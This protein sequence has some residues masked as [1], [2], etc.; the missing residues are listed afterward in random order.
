MITTLEHV[1]YHEFNTPMNAIVTLADCLEVRAK[2]QTDNELVE[3]C[4][5]L[6]SSAYRLCSTFTKLATLIQLTNDASA[7]VK[8]IQP[9]DIGLALQ[10][11]CTKISIEYNR[12]EDLIFNCGRNFLINVNKTYLESALNEIVDNAFKFSCLGQRV[13]IAIDGSWDKVIIRIADEGNT[14]NAQQ[15]QAC[16]F[17]KQHNR[18]IHEQQGLGIGLALANTIIR[19]YNGTIVFEDN[20]PCGIVVY[21]VFPTPYIIREVLYQQEAQEADTNC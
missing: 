1:L 9:V 2:Q 6:K 18:D 8:N 17:Y 16:G 11:I 13:N 15:L 4:T 7:C 5:L 21:I 19:F 14:A 20:L 3:L 12:E 10:S